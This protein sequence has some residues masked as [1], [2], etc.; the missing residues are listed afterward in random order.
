MQ[1]CIELQLNNIAK[2]KM[3]DS[4][5]AGDA[6]TASRAT[7]GKDELRN[8]RCSALATLVSVTNAALDGPEPVFIL[9]IDVENDLERPWGKV[10]RSMQ[11]QLGCAPPC[12]PP[13]Q[14][15]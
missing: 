5:G 8:T 2:A 1:R 4:E 3:M 7:P 10:A 11:V 12:A 15:S 9:N 13:P 14:W 6:Q